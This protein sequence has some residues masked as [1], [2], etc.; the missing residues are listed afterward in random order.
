MLKDKNKLI[1]NLIFGVFFLVTS[2]FI[3]FPKSS[4][5]RGKISV[6]LP[7][8]F[9]SLQYSLLPSDIFKRYHYDFRTD[10][11]IIET[12]TSYTVKAGDSF[13]NI[14]INSGI[15]NQDT[16][17]ILKKVR[18]HFN[19]SNIRKGTR[20]KVVTN[21]KNE[22][23]EFCYFYE[24]LKVL[25][26]KRSAD[27]W[28]VLSEDIPVEVRIDA[29]A[30]TLKSSL[31]ESIISLG[32]KESL[33]Y[34]IVNIF[35]WDIDFYIDPRNGDMFEVLF[36]KLY[37]R[38]KFYGY[39]KILF[40]HYSGSAAGNNYAYYYEYNGKDGYFNKDG[41]SLKSQF[42][43]SPL[44][45]TRISSGYTNRRFHPVLKIYR[46]HRGIDYAAPIGTPVKTVADGKVT[47][48]GWKGQ[49]GKVVIIQ[50]KNGYT[51]SY[52]HL[53]RIPNNI[54]PGVYVK[55]GQLIGYVGQ[56]G[57]ATGPHLDFRV[58]KNGVFI[59][60]LSLKKVPSEPVPVKY[61]KDFFKNRDE[62]KKQL[63]EILEK[64]YTE[65]E[66]ELEAGLKESL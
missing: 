29:I 5:G 40:V 52:G 30:G 37:V 39:G 31:Y 34:E 63:E 6:R 53:H 50:H 64:K 51:S 16:P 11:K 45:Y 19:P 10:Y 48:A 55:Q 9:P 2:L 47:Y 7:E 17:E 13:F 49:A 43:K 20:Y 15:P 35:Q 23:V 32:E 66:K 1:K 60:P 54:K 57:L 24:K 4:E 8:E 59:N 18:K 28:Q 56:T 62:Y 36:E 26:I 46:P 3:I 27:S 38:E 42:Q 58:K 61:K 25:S 44:K 65:A 22:L 41:N 14:L 21:G 33:I 12:E